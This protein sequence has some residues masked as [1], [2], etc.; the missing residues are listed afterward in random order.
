MNRPCVV[1]ARP[2]GP[3]DPTLAADDQGYLFA[4]VLRGMLAQGLASEVV[5]AVPDYVDAGIRNTLEGWGFAVA[6]GADAPQQRLAEV[7][8]AQDYDA[9]TVLTPYSCLVDGTALDA[10]WNGVESGSVDAVFT[11][12]VVAPKSFAVMNRH[13]ADVLAVAVAE[14]LPPFMFRTRLEETGRCRVME[15][16]GLESA[17]EEFL[18][19]TLFAGDVAALPSK[20]LSRFL[21]GREHREW[22]SRKQFSRL[23]ADV[24]GVQDFLPLEKSLAPLD[25][26]GVK[27]ASQVHFLR[28][29]APHMPDRGERFLEIGCHDQPLLAALAINRFRAGIA[30]EPYVFSEAGIR[31]AKALALALSEHAPA[32]V[33]LEVT[34]TR[35]GDFQGL[36]FRKATVE[37]LELDDGSVDFC[38][39]KV[40][41]EHVAD[42]PS[43]SR[44]LYRVLAPGAAMVHRIDFRD[45][46]RD[47]EA[48][49][50]NF[51]FLRHSRE[52]WAR[53]EQETNLWRVT[54]FVNLWQ[55]LGF[56]VEVLE[57][58][59]RVVR[60]ERVHPGWKDY[61]DEDL[62]CYDALIKAVK[63][64]GTD[65]RGK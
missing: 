2:M 47:H 57:R 55:E 58:R 59:T 35:Q 20:V 56:E 17:S 27:L 42:V 32:M 10:A 14:P 28:K 45:H 29:L 61:S 33:P 8:A 40:V 31:G 65:M 46:G 25:G 43:L 39:S 22:F 48:V 19:A 38:W 16:A 3:D 64:A 62:Y 12:K 60:P 18:W 21:R 30:V 50:I 63:P 53:M 1:L 11:G 9:C 49:Y 23:L 52:E 34:R 15:L 6:A 5:L 4:E 54:D 51:D 24:S 37:E 7:M 26:A 36:D 41:F 44:E 13:G